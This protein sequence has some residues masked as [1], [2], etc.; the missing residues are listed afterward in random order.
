M[1][2]NRM[3]EKKLLEGTMNMNKTNI[4]NLLEGTMYMNKTNIKNLLKGIMNMNKTDEK[5]K[6][7]D[8]IK[9]FLGITNDSYPANSLETLHQMIITTNLELDIHD[10]NGNKLSWN[11]FS[12]LEYEDCIFHTILKDRVLRIDKDC[13]MADLM[14]ICVVHTE[15]KSVIRIEYYE[16]HDELKLIYDIRRFDLYKAN[17]Q[18]TFKQG[19]FYYDNGLS[20]I[21]FNFLVDIHDNITKR[22][23]DIKGRYF[24][25]DPETL[26]QH[27]LRFA[28]EVMQKMSEM[29][30]N[31]ELDLRKPETSSSKNN[32]LNKEIEVLQVGEIYNKSGISY[33][34]DEKIKFNFNNLGGTIELV[35]SN[36]TKKEIDVIKN[37]KMKIGLLEKNGVMFVLVKFG[38]LPW[39]DMPYSPHLS[40]NFIFQDLNDNQGFAINIILVNGMNGKIE[41]LRLIGAPNKWS[42]DFKE[43]TLE[44]KNKPFSKSEFENNL[45]DVYNNYSTATLLKYANV[46]NIN[47]L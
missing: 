39:F 47:S 46:Y 40:N 14:P 38:S 34:C 30:Q 42:D 28:T 27:T 44:H 2:S 17:L 33:P 6:K 29:S 1:L 21:G 11:D 26:E 9:H 20:A 15:G 25:K 32:F 35:F 13:E 19:T 12:N 5:N 43:L 41:C 10:E 22:S 7:D 36:P 18:P 3:H 37:G 8:F 45:R 4:K 31:P 23:E 16:G 24:A